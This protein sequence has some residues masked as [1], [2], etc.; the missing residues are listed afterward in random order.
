MK[1]QPQPNQIQSTYNKCVQKA[2]YA[3]YKNAKAL[4]STLDSEELR[5]TL[6]RK[7]KGP[8]KVGSILHE[9]VN[10]IL[11][12]RLECHVTNCYAIHYG[13]EEAESWTPF[14]KITSAFVRSIYKQ[15]AKAET[16]VNIE[17]SVR[18]DYCIYG[19][20]DAYEHVDEHSCYHHFKRIE[21]KPLAAK[22][23]QM[24]A[25]A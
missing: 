5:C 2:Y 1:Q 3:I 11:Y 9:F 7:D 6:E 25:V 18:T 17:D 23:K 8:V 19:C 4:L 14:A 20:S 21:Y 13:F 12:L 22:R 10:P 15:T 16:E 24:H